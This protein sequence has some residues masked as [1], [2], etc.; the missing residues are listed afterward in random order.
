MNISLF[1]KVVLSEIL[2]LVVGFTNPCLGRQSALTRQRIHFDKYCFV[3]PFF[4]K[5][6]IFILIIITWPR[7]GLQPAGSRWII[8][9]RVPNLTTFDHHFES[10]FEI[11]VVTRF[12][13]FFCIFHSFLTPQSPH[14][15]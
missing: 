1:V 8:S 4:Y 7:L 2:V 5:I 12:G 11:S 3:E 6:L 13:I 10:C 15:K 14:P 9:L